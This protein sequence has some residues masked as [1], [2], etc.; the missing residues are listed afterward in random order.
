MR[1]LR[2]RSGRGLVIRLWW[3]LPGVLATR[4]AHFQGQFLQWP[5]HRLER[6][7]TIDGNR[8]GHWRTVFRG[9]EVKS[10]SPHHPFVI[11]LHSP[12]QIVETG[13]PMCPPEKSRDTGA[14]YCPAVRSPQS[15]SASD[16][17]EKWAL[18]AHF[19]GS[20]GG[21]SGQFRL[22]G[23]GRGIR[24]PGTVSRTSVFKT[25]CFNHSHIPPLL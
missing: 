6:S 3:A 23:G 10:G 25:D 21:T 12:G 14:A 13:L 9:T 4:P 18:F 22:A 17:P 20:A 15:I 24:T 7:Q 11:A 2:V 19:G 5:E 8:H 16:N 1:C